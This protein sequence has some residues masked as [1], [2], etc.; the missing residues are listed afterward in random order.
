MEFESEQMKSD[1]ESEQMKSDV[2]YATYMVRCNDG[3]LYTGYST[4]VERRVKTHNSG[5]GAKYT[6]ARRPVELVY[7][8][9][10]K[11][12]SDALKREV[13]IKKLTRTKK[14]LLIAEY[15]ERT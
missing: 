8:E 1:D 3:S 12:K 10:S 15:Q 2:R 4:D 9:Y 6:R 11:T 13:A 14:E 5:K 7:V